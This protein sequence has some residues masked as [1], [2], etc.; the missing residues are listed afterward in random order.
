[1]N[2]KGCSTGDI[3]NRTIDETTD[4]NILIDNRDKFCALCNIGD[5]ILIFRCMHSSYISSHL[6]LN[7][8]QSIFLHIHSS[9]NCLKVYLILGIFLNYYIGDSIDIYFIFLIL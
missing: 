1:M 5:V 6:I 4:D 3:I 9:L 2:Y 8:V 7:D